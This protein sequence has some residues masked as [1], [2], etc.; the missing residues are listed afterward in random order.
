MLFYPSDHP[1]PPVADGC[2]QFLR[3]FEVNSSIPADLGPTLYKI[4]MLE[5][6][7]IS[8]S[9]F[10]MRQLQ[11]SNSNQVPQ[12]VRVTR[13]DA[14]FLGEVVPLR[15]S[16]D[17]RFQGALDCVARKVIRAVRVTCGQQ[18]SCFRQPG[19]REELQILSIHAPMVTPRQA[20]IR[21]QA[22]SPSPQM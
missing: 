4:P 9:F 18:C 13:I 14:L 6:D 10:R 8:S 16:C 17:A 19:S 15:F 11:L 5:K 20:Y 2:N 3:A 21:L 12:I 7:G 22:L 1:M